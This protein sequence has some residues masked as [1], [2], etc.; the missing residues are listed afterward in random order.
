VY[1]GAIPDAASQARLQA[2]AGALSAVWP[3]LGGPTHSQLHITVGQCHSS[4]AAAAVRELNSVHMA[5]PLRFPVRAV[6]VVGRKDAGL[7][8]KVTTGMQLA[9]P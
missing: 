1:I 9:R 5:A 6:V 8:F 3:W 7:P 4:E 2:L